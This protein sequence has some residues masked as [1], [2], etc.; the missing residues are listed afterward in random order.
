[1]YNEFHDL[2]FVGAGSEF[3]NNTGDGFLRHLDIDDVDIPVDLFIQFLFGVL[4]EVLFFVAL[5]YLHT[6]KR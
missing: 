5:K 2:K 6:G 1:M 3:Y 4:F